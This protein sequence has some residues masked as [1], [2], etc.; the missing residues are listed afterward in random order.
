MDPIRGALTRAELALATGRPID[1]ETAFRGVLATH[2]G[3]VRALDGLST[4]LAEQG[5]WGDALADRRAI[6]GAASV[7]GA[8]DR[9]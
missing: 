8:V 6:E 1:A 9:P 5:R 3:D 2:P 4:A 7:G